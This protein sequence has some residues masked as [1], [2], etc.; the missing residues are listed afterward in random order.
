MTQKTN[1][2][3][4]T[5][6]LTNS[7]LLVG[8]DEARKNYELAAQEEC[9]DALYWLGRYAQNYEGNSKK[10]LKFYLKAA[11]LD[12]DLA[13]TALGNLY[14]EGL[15][16]RKN[17]KIAEYYYQQSALQDNTE[18]MLKIGTLYDIGG[19]GVRKN[20]TVA[21]EWYQKAADNNNSSAM[22]LIGLMYEVDEAGSYQDYELA[23]HWYKKALALG[24]T[25][26]YVMLGDLYSLEEKLDERKAI[27]M[28]EAGVKASK[29]QAL[30]NLGNLY[31]R[32]LG[33]IDKD[34]TKAV[35]YYT[36][37]YRYKKESESY[38]N[39]LIRIYTKGGYGMEVDLG[40]AKYWK[41]VKKS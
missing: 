40:K 6:A 19:K 26:A 20:R 35:K 24:N 32:G 41:T 31:Y 27:R 12:N 34:Y 23:E 10:A 30:L 16:V 29:P 8:H 3:V 18:A 15:G 7:S 39:N 9:P 28:Y 13:F 36:E 5:V 22:L 14:K 38:I 11:K 25:C 1:H 21:M 2:I 17:Y 33:I 37:Y 4:A